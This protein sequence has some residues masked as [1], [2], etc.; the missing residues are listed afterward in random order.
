MYVL[1]P[2][3]LMKIRSKLKA[4]SIGQCQIW[5]FWHSSADNSKVARPDFELIRDFMPLLLISNFDED[6]IKKNEDTIPGATFAT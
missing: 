2:A 6:P 1:L 3:S 4:L 5:A